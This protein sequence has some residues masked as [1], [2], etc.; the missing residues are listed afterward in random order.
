M[1]TLLALFALPLLTVLALAAD[2]EPAKDAP[3]PADGGA[4]VVIDAAGKEQKLKSWKIVGGTRRLGWLAPAGPAPKKAAPKDDDEKAAPAGPEALAF[5]EGEEI[6]FVEGV[7]TL[8]PLDRVRSVDYDGEKETVTAKVVVPGGG[9]ESLVGST[10]Y[11]GINKLALEAEIDKGD[12]GVAE[13]RYSGGGPKGIR[14]IR[15]PGT[16]APAAGPAGRSATV[17]SIDGMTKS[18]HKVSDLMPLYRFDDGREKLVP[19]LFFRKTLKIDIGKVRRLAAGETDKDDPAW[20]VQLKDGSDE[21][22]VLLTAPEIEGHKAHL[23][24]LVG[25]VPAGY[26]LFPAATISEVVFE[27]AEK[28]PEK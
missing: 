19:T 24:G 11:K 4:L 2:K 27:A 3:R 1:R 5:R 8:V 12:L 16:G 25:R 22:F 10:K 20:Q 13:V 9:E 7:L 18:T 17:T 21:S 23:E 6:H 15:F 28:A 26:K 14:G